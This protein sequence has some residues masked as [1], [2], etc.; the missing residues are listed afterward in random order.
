MFVNTFLLLFVLASPPPDEVI[1]I[2]GATGGGYG[3]FSWGT[4]LSTVETL[5]PKLKSASDQVRVS[6]ENRALKRLRKAR[7]QSRKKRKDGE[8]KLS[9]YRHWTSLGGLK[10]MVTLLF[11]EDQ[12]S[13]AAVGLLFSRGQHK[14]LQT[15]LDAMISKYGF[16]EDDGFQSAPLDRPR[17]HRF[18]SVD[19]QII[20]SIIPADDASPGYLEIVYRAAIL[21]VQIVAYLQRLREE[22]ARLDPPKSTQPHRT[23]PRKDPLLER[24]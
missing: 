16:P 20:L 2:R 11:Y 13:E 9:A 19:S 4:S 21:D 12:L 10:G 18:S 24:L 22:T 6:E 5:S 7:S 1:P 3:Q 8:A 15:L 23:P 17:Q 14:K